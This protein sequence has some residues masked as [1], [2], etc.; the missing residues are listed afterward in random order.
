VTPQHVKQMV[1]PVLRHRVA[2]TPELEIEGMHVDQVIDALMDR[3]EAPR[4]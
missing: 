1:K 2:L 4:T 3:V